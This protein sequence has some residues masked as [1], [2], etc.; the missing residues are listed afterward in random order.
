MNGMIIKDDARYDY[1]EN[2]LKNCG[3]TFNAAKNLNFVIFP[4]KGEVDLSKYD[5]SFFAELKKGTPIFSGVLNMALA[6]KCE[7]YGLEYHAMIEKRG[8]AIKNAVPT[9]EGVL[10]YLIANRN[11]TIAGSR[12][13]VVGY[14]IC[15]SDLCKRLKALGADVYSLVRNREKESSAYTDGITPLYLPGIF[16]KTSF[17]IIINTVPERVLSNKMLSK[18][19]GAILID[20]ASS[21]YGFDIGYA[22]KLNEKSAI[23]PGLPGKFAAKTAGEILGEYINY[24]LSGGQ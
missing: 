21:P 11:E 20:I 4:F 16:E 22:K 5:D 18:T 17:D 3:H 14:G 13:L 7:K 15:G 24:I 6:Y 23:L 9:S 19:N 12:V 8:V 1:C 10:T 2:F